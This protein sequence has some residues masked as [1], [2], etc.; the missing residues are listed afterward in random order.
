MAENWNSEV[1]VCNAALLMLGDKTIQSLDQQNNTKATLCNF[2][3]PNTRDAVLR[4]FPW[5]FAG[6]LA[7][8]TKFTDPPEFDFDYRFQLPDDFVKARYL[9]DR[10]TKFK[11]VGSELHSDSDAIKL[12]Y[13][14][15]VIDISQW[16][17]LAVMALA[18]KL[19]AVLAYPVTKSKST[20]E[21]QMSLYKDQLREAG[22]IDSQ[23]QTPDSLESDELLD[24]RN[25][26]ESPGGYYIG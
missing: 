22:E 9:S 11:L 21:V 6:A 16:D 1:D 3:Y 15:R 17:E 2:W 12:K 10:S 26:S 24:V 7:D 18:M 23:E 8:L 13:T 25:G 4:A 5:N 20:M 19:S 14:K